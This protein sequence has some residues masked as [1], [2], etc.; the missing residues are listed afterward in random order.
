[1]SDA[2]VKFIAKLEV[3][4]PL[5]RHQTDQQKT[6]WV[7]SMVRELRGFDSATL[8]RAADDIIRR[9]T[10]TRF[11]LPSECLRACSEAK[12]WIDADRRMHSLPMGGQQQHGQPVSAMGWEER[13]R[14]ADDLVKCPVGRQAAQE[15]W[16]GALHA[17]AVKFGRLPPA[18]EFGALK[19]EAKETDRTIADVFRGEAPNAAGEVLPIDPAMR[20]VLVKFANDVLAKRKRLEAK[21]LGVRP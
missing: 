17:Y 19:R 14:L 3:H 7:H 8:L 12:K 2:V 9:R 16:I 15:G 1:M 13:E 18:G 20:G 4:Y 11:P 6:E 10:D 5:P 21:V